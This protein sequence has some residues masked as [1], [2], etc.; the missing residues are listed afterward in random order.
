MEF[1]QSTLS[2]AFFL[3]FKVALFASE[4]LKNYAL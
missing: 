4:S 2:F 1:F 3:Q